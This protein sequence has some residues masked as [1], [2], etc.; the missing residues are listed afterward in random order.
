[1]YLPSGIRVQVLA[2]CPL[3]APDNSAHAPRVRLVGR[4]RHGGEVATTL[5]RATA[6]RPSWTI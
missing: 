3:P 4:T 2:V 5:P 1:V 6:L